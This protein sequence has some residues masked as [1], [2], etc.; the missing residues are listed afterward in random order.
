[1][2]LEPTDALLVPDR[3]LGDDQAGSYLLVVN[4]DNV[5][6][7]RARHDRASC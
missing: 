1:M 7:Q 3:V 6:E 4:K 5:V 2:G